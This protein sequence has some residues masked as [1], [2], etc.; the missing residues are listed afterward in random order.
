MTMNMDAT[1]RE[2]LIGLA[3]LHCRL[4][5][6]EGNRMD[7]KAMRFNAMA[8]YMQHVAACG[9]AHP[10]SALAEAVETSIIGNIMHTGEPFDC[11]AYEW[12]EAP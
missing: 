12:M 10:L 2:T 5:A 11:K 6:M 1:A 8:D 4:A 9:S 7:K 3:A